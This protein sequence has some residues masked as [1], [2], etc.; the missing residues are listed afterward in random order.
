MVKELLKSVKGILFAD[1]DLLYKEERHLAN[2][3][4]YFEGTNG[5]A[6]LLVHGWTSTPYEVRRLGNT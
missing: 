2:Q 5:K 1:P 6:V 3:P 4:F